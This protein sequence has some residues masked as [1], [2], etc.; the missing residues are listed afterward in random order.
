MTMIEA[1]ALIWA[2]ES[3][4][5]RFK[6]VFIIVWIIYITMSIPIDYEAYGLLHVVIQHTIL[7][8]LYVLNNII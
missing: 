1:I 8:T 4:E 5:S 7:L 6:R 2:C 3:F